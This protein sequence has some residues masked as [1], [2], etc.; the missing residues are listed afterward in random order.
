MKNQP[1]IIANRYLTLHNGYFA[2]AT[3]NGVYIWDKSGLLRHHF[4]KK[5]GLTAN[6]SHNLYEDDTG[7]LWVTGTDGISAI[8]LF[9]PMRQLLPGGLLPNEGIQDVAEF[10]N[11]LII[12]TQKG[13][14]ISQGDRFTN[15][16][17]EVIIYNLTSGQ[18]GLWLSTNEGLYLLSKELEISKIYDESGIMTVS[19]PYPGSNTRFISTTDGQINVM[20]WNNN[21]G[22]QP[23]PQ[24][25]EL[26]EAGSTAYSLHIGAEGFHWAGLGDRILRINLHHENEAIRA[27]EATF[28]TQRDGL[29]ANSFNY[30]M[31]VR[32]DVG[33]ITQNGFYRLN[34]SRDSIIKDTRFDQLFG[35]E[36]FPV[37]PVYNDPQGN[38]WTGRA[39]YKI[40]KAVYNSQYGNF[41]WHE[42]EYTRMAP[43][44]DVDNFHVGKSGR[45]Y[46]QTFNRIAFYDS[47]ITHK[48]LPEPKM[49]ITK[50]S[51]V[52]D[53]LLYTGWGI[54]Q[55]NSRPEYHYQTNSL[56]FTWALIDFKPVNYHN[57]QFKM[58]GADS[59]WSDWSGELSA[60]YRNL[61]EGTYR[62]MVRGRDIYNRITPVSSFSF[63]VLPPWYRSTWAYGLYLITLIGLV[64]GAWRWRNRKLLQQQKKLETE[65]QER[66]QKLKQKKEQLEKLDHVK[67][68][69]FSNVSHEFRT[70]MTLIKGPAGHLL[71][72]DDQK[73]G[74]DRNR[75]LQQIIKN[76]DRLLCLLHN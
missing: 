68:T 65:V 46:F 12:A 30:T 34:T 52:E 41:D 66:T 17:G 23:Q 5:N 24:I 44:K 32:D 8:E 33:F 42:D 47:T 43:L 53:S 40:G 62:F 49:H 7:T 3:S 64:A 25:T 71:E 61:R 10:Q 37:W 16:L 48:P 50:V 76:A 4:T 45:I 60:D 36:G 21:S 11:H 73:Q 1:K 59:D 15:T 63:R 67:T 72:A 74:K 69:F 54:N 28:F 19:E 70:P 39:A 29:P 6:Y 18:R 58:E 13:L 20:F 75:Q 2:A 9:R 55:N 35:S 31:Q 14:L 56:R 22:G 26:Y 38:L 27:H 57:Y 51:T